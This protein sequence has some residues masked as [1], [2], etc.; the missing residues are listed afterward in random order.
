MIS[1]MREKRFF[2]GMTLAD[3]W[4]KTKINQGKLSQLERGI[5]IPTQKEKEAIAR[6][7]K[8]SVKEIFPE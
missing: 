6:A 8:S 7:L 4:L 2:A 3:L 1:K 5:F